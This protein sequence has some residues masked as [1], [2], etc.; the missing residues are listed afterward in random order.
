MLPGEDGAPK[1]DEDTLKTGAAADVV[2]TDASTESQTEPQEEVVVSIGDEP[3]DDAEEEQAAA[4]AWV[5]KVRQRNRE[6]ERELKETKKKLQEVVPKEVEL[7]EK[8]TLENCDYDTTKYEQALTTWYDKKKKADERANAAK[9]ESENAEKAWQQK[10]ETYKQSKANFKAQ[11]FDDVEAVALDVLDQVQQG[12]IVHGATDAALVIYAL[13]KNEAKAKEMAAIKD[14][15]K[16]AFAIAKLEGQLKVTTKKPSTVPET[17]IN[18]NSKPSGAVDNTLER[19]RSEA[20]KTGD[21]SKV[22]AYKRSKR[23]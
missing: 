6:L 1:I 3:A 8:P 14:P 19:L 10:L 16:F 22:V 17:R 20:E 9:V 13:G 15:V 2:E 7:G 11:D 5:K 4:P 23:G 18:G 21:F 12:I